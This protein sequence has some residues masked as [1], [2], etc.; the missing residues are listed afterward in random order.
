MEKNDTS[1]SWIGKNTQCYVENFHK[2]GKGSKNKC[3]LI[4]GMF[5]CNYAYCIQV[6]LD[7]CITFENSCSFKSNEI[8]Q[9]AFVHVA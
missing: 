7:F 5:P 3:G 2:A 9:I 6:T 8:H 1:F 4:H